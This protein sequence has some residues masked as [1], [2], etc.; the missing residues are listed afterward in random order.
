MSQSAAREKSKNNTL[1]FGTK[2]HFNLYKETHTFFPSCFYESECQQYVNL[3]VP[4]GLLTLTFITGCVTWIY[5]SHL[6]A[7]WASAI[8]CIT[9]A[10]HTVAR[11]VGSLRRWC[12][13]QVTNLHSL[14]SNLQVPRF[15]SQGKAIFRSTFPPQYPF[16]KEA[17]SAASAAGHN[18]TPESTEISVLHL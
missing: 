6:Y 3:N 10:W 2:V 14:K 11:T 1:R 4:Q 7:Q 9:L 13:I 16:H 18:I 5:L 12:P 17:D 15:K 8:P